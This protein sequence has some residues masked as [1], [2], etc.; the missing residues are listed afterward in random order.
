MSK[1]IDIVLNLSEKPNVTTESIRNFY[2]ELEIANDLISDARKALKE[3]VD[4]NEEI[5]SINDEITAL[6]DRKK[7]I[8]DENPVLS[9]YKE[10]LLSA[11]NNR[12][13]LIRDAK[14]DGIPRGEISLAER[15]LKKDLDMQISTEIYSNIADL[16]DIT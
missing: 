1:K 5:T 16:V 12:K 10:E 6:R 2:K 4:G 3:A 11:V 13:D 15:A 8:I 7:E 14:S 9:A